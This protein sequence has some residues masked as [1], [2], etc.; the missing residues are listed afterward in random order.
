VKKQNYL[1][2]DKKFEINENFEE[3]QKFL[4]NRIYEFFQSIRTISKD[5][6][7]ISDK[8]VLMT[9]YHHFDLTEK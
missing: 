3:I 2:R 6:L 4:T 5:Y 8:C 9:S 1:N 7:G